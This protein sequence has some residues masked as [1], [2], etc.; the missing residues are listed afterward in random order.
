MVKSV[1]RC[2]HYLPEAIDSLFL[3]DLDHWGLE[4]LYNDLVD[5]QNELLKKDK[6]TNNA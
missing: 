1:I 6:K 2:H 5:E 4:W 3:D